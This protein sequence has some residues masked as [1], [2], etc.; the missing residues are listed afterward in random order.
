MR[1]LWAGEAA[2]L[3]PLVLAAIEDVQEGPST[4]IDQLE[5]DMRAP[6]LLQVD[7]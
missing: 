5:V 2:R 3:P 6:V 1:D 7:L 4:N